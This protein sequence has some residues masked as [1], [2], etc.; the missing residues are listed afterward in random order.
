MKKNHYLKLIF[1]G[2]VT[3]VAIGTTYFLVTEQNKIRHQQR[4]LDRVRDLFK[5]EGK[6]IGSYIET[7]PRPYKHANVSTMAYFG[8]IT[9]E[10]QGQIFQYQFVL[11]AKTYTLIDLKLIA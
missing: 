7:T 1:T 6:I 11:S 2:A 9:R 3:A 8:G 4:A 10:D 5:D